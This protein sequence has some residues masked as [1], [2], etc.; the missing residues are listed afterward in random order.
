MVWDYEIQKYTG[1]YH[2]ELHMQDFIS[3]I[4]RM[5]LATDYFSHNSPLCILDIGTLYVLTRT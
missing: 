2:R 4:V 3:E 1:I 5:L